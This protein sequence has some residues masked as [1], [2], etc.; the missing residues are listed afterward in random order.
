MHWVQGELFSL[1]HA[2]ED[3]LEH[4]FASLKRPYQGTPTFKDLVVAAQVH[5]TRQKNKVANAAN[6]QQ[7][8]KLQHWGAFLD[9]MSLSCQTGHLI[10]LASLCLL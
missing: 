8:T 9:L 1:K 2:Q 4:Y 6:L 5:H 10:L 3:Q 7:H